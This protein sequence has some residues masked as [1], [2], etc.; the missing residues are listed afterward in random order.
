MPEDQLPLISRVITLK[1]VSK[2]CSEVFNIT[3]LPDVDSIN[4]LGG[5]NFSYPRLAF[6]DGAQDP[7]RA[8]G[9][10]HIDLPERESTVD[11]PFILVDYGVHHW[12]ENGPD[13]ATQYLPDF[14]PAHVLKVQ[15][16]EVEFVQAWVKDFKEQKRGK[17]VEEFPG[18]L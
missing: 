6:I 14:P 16:Q 2:F 17:L 1:Y 3:T 9:V 13:N 12:D 7:W 4:K 5:A 15:D 10:H 18:D 8:A 11:E